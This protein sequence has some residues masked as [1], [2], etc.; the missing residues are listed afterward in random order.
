MMTWGTALMLAVIQGLTEFLPVSSSGHLALFQNFLER[1]SGQ[2]LPDALAFD[3]L[4]HVGTMLAVLIYFRRDLL[5]LF[6]SLA[7]AGPSEKQVEAARHGRREIGFLALSLVP[8]AIVGLALRS[9]ADELLHRPVVV[10]ALVGVTGVILTTTRFTATN[11]LTPSRAGA[12]LTLPRALAMGAAQGLA[13]L[14]G[15][16]RSGLTIAAG[17]AGGLPPLAAFR[18]SFLMSIP[19]IAG[20]AVLELGGRPEALGSLGLPAAVAAVVAGLVALAALAI[21]SRSLRG[22]RFHLFSWY[23]FAVAVLGVSLFSFWG[24]K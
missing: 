24:G 15:L 22:G 5:L 20:A 12:R 14:P 9:V 3:V 11:G 2:S 19:T 16:S 10:A 1:L 4:L 17:L 7:P 13:V 23:C 18:L 8:T 21:L 6:S